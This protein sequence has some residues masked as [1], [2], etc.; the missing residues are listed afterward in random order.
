MFGQKCSKEGGFDSE[1]FGQFVQNGIQMFQSGAFHNATEG[2]QGHRGHGQHDG[3]WKQKKATLIGKPQSTL[4]G[5]PGQVIFADIEV[6][7]NMN[8]AWKPHASLQS[9][10]TPM[11]ASLLDEVAIPIDF[12][13]SE[14]STFKLSIPMKIKESAS[15]SD[16]E[17]EACFTFVGRKGNSFGDKIVIKFKI[18]KEIDEVYFYQTAMELYEKQDKNSKDISFDVIVKILKYTNGDKAKA[19]QLITLKKIDG[20]QQVDKI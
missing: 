19:E 1:K 3:V 16:Q 2:N 9:D 10:F 15:A 14:N 13:V 17:F 11:I 4:I 7:N 12:P 6:K 18:Q 8:W 5:K 20:H